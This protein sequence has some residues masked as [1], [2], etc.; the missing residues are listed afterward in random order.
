MAHPGSPASQNSMIK[1]QRK[2]TMLLERAGPNSWPP[3]ASPLFLALPSAA[4]VPL[5][6]LLHPRPTPV[7]HGALDVFKP[8]RQCTFLK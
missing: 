7:N 8:S 4:S 2:V 1:M 6:L 5:L 3:V